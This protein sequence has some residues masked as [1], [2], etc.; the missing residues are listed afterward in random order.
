MISLTIVIAVSWKLWFLKYS[1]GW[2]STPSE[3]KANKF[4]Y[5]ARIVFECPCCAHQWRDEQKK[6]CPNCEVRMTYAQSKMPSEDEIKTTLEN[7][8][9]DMFLCDRD[10]ST[11]QRYEI[12]ADTILTLIKSKRDE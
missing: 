3:M 10:Y 11:A 12:L 7:A 9:Y 5:T 8:E 6:Y 4:Q 2:N 1:D